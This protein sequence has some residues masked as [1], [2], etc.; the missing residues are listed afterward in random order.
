M[1]ITPRERLARMLDGSQAPGA[2]SAQLFRLEAK[3]H[4]DATASLE[5]L[6]AQRRR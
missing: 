2:S 6:A 1:P 3:A 5:W 4:K